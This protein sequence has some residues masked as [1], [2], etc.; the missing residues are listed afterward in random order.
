[1]DHETVTA[2]R[3]S[4]GGVTDD[5]IERIRERIA[6]GTWGPGTRLPREADLAKQLGLSRNSLREAVRALSLARV[7]EVRRGDGTYVSSLE[8]DE[9]L[10][11]TLSPPPTCF[12]A[13]RSSNC[14]R[15]AA[16]SSPRRRRWRRSASTTT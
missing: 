2:G 4:R 6:S 1:M 5:A 13:G 12:A 8:P 3:R 9:L 15:C 11:P 10:E 14:S 16:C 7:L